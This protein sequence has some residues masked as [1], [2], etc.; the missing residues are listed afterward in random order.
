[1]PLHHGQG[2]VHES[3]DLVLGCGASKAVT[4]RPRHE[5]GRRFPTR[6]ADLVAG[7]AMLARSAGGPALLDPDAVLQRQAVRLRKLTTTVAVLHPDALLQRQAVRLHAQ[8]G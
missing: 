5:Y 8:G 1:M 2:K 3:C 7:T 6:C 4:K